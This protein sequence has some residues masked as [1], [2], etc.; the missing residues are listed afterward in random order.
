MSTEATLEQ[1]LLDLVQ[2][3]PWLMEALR[4]ARSLGLPD[5]CLGAGV[6]RNLVWDHLHGHPQPT[7]AGDLDLCF[8]D[9]LDQSAERDAAL[10]RR[11]QQ[12]RPQ[13]PWEVT[14][15]AGVHL[16]FEAHFGHAVAPLRSLEQAIATWPGTATAVGVRLETDDR[17]TLLA[18][19]GLEDLFAGVVRR[20][21]ARVSVATYLQRIAS[22]RYAQS[23]PGLQILP[24]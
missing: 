5:W 7:P 10:Q 22:K 16:W 21:P 19:L 23:W 6:L 1:R 8:F 24:P 14:N 20:N 3:A 2:R 13:I 18:P 17:L 11:L 12:L 9:S 15:Q 4:C